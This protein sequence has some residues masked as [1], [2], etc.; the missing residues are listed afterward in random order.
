LIEAG[1]DIHC[2]SEKLL[3]LAASSNL[4]LVKFLIEKYK[5]NPCCQNDIAIKTARACGKL[6]IEKYLESFDPVIRLKKIIGTKEVVDVYEIDECII[7]AYSKYL[8]S[9]YFYSKHQELV[10]S[11]I[12]NNKIQILKLLIKNGASP[13]FSED[14]PLRVAAFVGNV[15]IV[16]YL[17]ED[18]KADVHAYGDSA[19]I[20]AAKNGHIKVLQYLIENC[21]CDPHLRDDEILRTPVMYNQIEIVKYL[22]EVC[23]LNPHN[24]QER[25]LI[26]AAQYGFLDLV[27][28]F[29]EVHFCNIHVED[30]EPMKMA[31][32]YGKADI[33]EYLKSRGSLM[34]NKVTFIGYSGATIF[35]GLVVFDRK[36]KFHQ[37]IDTLNKKLPDLF[38][39][40]FGS[41]DFNF[42]SKGSETECRVCYIEESRIVQ[43][44]IL[45]IKFEV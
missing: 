35:D 13:N 40:K 9:S 15:E 37:F 24:F 31:I 45:K 41:D 11:T 23:K 33:V 29:V 14:H 32:K 10:L 12:E 27:K 43:N 30:D 28:Y 8:G 21:H 2:D 44:G 26:I 25:C 39:L 16:K 19:M 42:V 3:K 18:C 22:V 7:N 5:V 6:E 36:T 20:N 34:K 1:A 38:I 17:V 4:D